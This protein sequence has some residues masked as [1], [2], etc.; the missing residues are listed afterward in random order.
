MKGLIEGNLGLPPCV[1]T[2]SVRYACYMTAMGR[3]SRHDGIEAVIK[4]QGKSPRC[5]RRVAPC[6]PRY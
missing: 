5:E 2:H 6:Q 3:L 4:R 1:R